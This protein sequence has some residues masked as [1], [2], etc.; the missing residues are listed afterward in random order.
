[1]KNDHDILIEHSVDINYIK[2]GIDR[3]ESKMDI[4]TQSCNHK[5]SRKVGW[6][7]LGIIV[8]I[9]GVVVGLVVILI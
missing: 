7:Q 5:L 6:H 3:V 8:S 2:Q 1:M 9:I 4:L